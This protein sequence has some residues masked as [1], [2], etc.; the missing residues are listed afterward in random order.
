MTIVDQLDLNLYSEVTVSVR[1]LPSGGVMVTLGE[2]DQE[3]VRIWGSQAAFQRL[4]ARLDDALTGQGD[5]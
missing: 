2:R 5:D 1:V 4:T 3:T